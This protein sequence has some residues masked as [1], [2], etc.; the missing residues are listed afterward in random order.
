MSFKSIYGFPGYEIGSDGSIWS[1][2]I[3][4]KWKK[5]KLQDNGAGYL[6]VILYKKDGYTN[7][8]ILVHKLVLTAFRGKRPK[9]MECRHLD[10][11]RGN[12]NLYNLQWG[13]IHENIKDKKRHGNFIQGEKQ[14][15]SK[16]T[17]NDVRQIRKLRKEKGYTLFKLAK[18][19]NV[20]FTNIGLIIQRKTWKHV[21]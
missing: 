19:F 6:T 7:E 2:R 15:A 16:I 18:I 3:G 21:I 17:E 20:T 14:W 10:G 5:M 9:G 8:R 11:N 1:R 12:N 13:T 4:N